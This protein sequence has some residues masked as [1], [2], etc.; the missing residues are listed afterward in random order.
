M[1]I[2]YEKLIDS[3]IIVAHFQGN[4]TLYMNHLRCAF[5]ILHSDIFK[6]WDDNIRLSEKCDAKYVK[7]S[8]ALIRMCIGKEQDYWRKVNKLAKDT[9]NYMAYIMKFNY[10]GVTEY[11]YSD[12]EQESD[13]DDNL[14]I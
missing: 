4:T 12:A 14:D 9:T 7:Q 2:N 5:K 3:A 1:D 8:E 10:E 13:D 6:F 11:Q